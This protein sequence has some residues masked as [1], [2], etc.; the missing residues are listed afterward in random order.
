MRDARLILSNIAVHQNNLVEAE[1]WLE[2]ILDEY[3]ADIGALNDL[4]YL[5]ADQGKKLHRALQMI[6]KAV[7]AEP[8]NPAYRDSLGWVLFRLER[9][10][11]AVEELQRAAEIDD[12]S[13]GVLQ[14]HLGDALRATG[15]VQAAKEAYQK[16]VDAL[17]KAGEAKKADEIRK[18]L[19]EQ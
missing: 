12:S 7:E 5:Y 19:S 3:P 8:K 4:G 13:D 15:Q 16:A 18:K 14:D 17:D 9:F 2:Q 11:E 10:A 1:E 6:Q